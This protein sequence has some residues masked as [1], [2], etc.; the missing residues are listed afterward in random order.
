MLQFGPAQK[1]PQWDCFER[2]TVVRYRNDRP[3]K[4]E[5]FI[6]GQCHLRSKQ[7]QRPFY[8][9]PDGKGEVIKELLTNSGAKI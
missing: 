3:R 8:T 9:T 1:F 2:S 7:I 4:S 5:P 6:E